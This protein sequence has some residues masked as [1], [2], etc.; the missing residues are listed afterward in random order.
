MRFSY[1]DIPVAIMAYRYRQ[2]VPER[3]PLSELRALVRG[4]LRPAGVQGSGRRRA[5]D[6][7]AVVSGI[8]ENWSDGAVASPSPPA[9]E[10][11]VRQ[12][13]R[14][15]MVSIT[16]PRRGAGRDCVDTM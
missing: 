6:V 4:D 14:I 2:L 7:D 16:P 10:G 13:C 1:G 12:C 9:G 3:P 15:V 8:E 5:A 11:S